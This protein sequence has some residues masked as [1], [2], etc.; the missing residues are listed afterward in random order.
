MEWLFFF[1]FVQL[2][3]NTLCH[4]VRVWRCGPNMK[5]PWTGGLGTPPGQARRC[6][7]HTHAGT[8]QPL[9][10]ASESPDGPSVSLL[11]RTP[12]LLVPI[13]QRPSSTRASWRAGGRAHRR[14][15]ATASP[16]EDQNANLPA[17]RVTP[18]L[19]ARPRRFICREVCP[20][21]RITGPKQDRP[22]PD[23]VLKAVDQHWSQSRIVCQ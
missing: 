15:T 6:S 9:S 12:G 23:G 21:R 22:D 3:S 19:V 5:A 20:F 18:R 14:A 11:G 2:T 13:D 8:E 4:A 17:A 10:G 16:A 1:F 7:Q